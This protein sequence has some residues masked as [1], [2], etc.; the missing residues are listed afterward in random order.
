M[1]P[2]EFETTFRR[3]LVQAP[4]GEG[5]AG[6]VFRVADDDGMIYALKF[7]R[8]ESATSSKRKRFQN[9]IRFCQAQEH[10]NIIKVLDVGLSVSATAASPF[11]VMPFYPQTLRH[12][13]QAGI[14][15]DNILPLFA[16]ILDGV[17]AAHLV[18]VYHRDL[19]P[20]NV[21]YDPAARQMVVADFGV[22]HFAEEQLYTE[23]E[24]K[25]NERLANF[26]YSSPE[27]RARGAVVDQRA[28]IFALGLILNEMYTGTVIHGTGHRVIADAAP[29]YSYLDALVDAMIRQSTQERL[30][31]IRTIK[32]QLIARRQEFVSC[33]RLDQLRNVAVLDSQPD[34]PLFQRQVSIADVDYQG[35]DLVFTFEPTP[36]ATWTS[37]F[38]NL[39]AFQGFLG[40]GPSAMRFIGGQGMISAREHEVQQMVG[41]VR[42]W[43]QSANVEHDRRI[44]EDARRRDHEERRRIE[45]ELSAEEQ[46]QRILRNARAALE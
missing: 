26:L 18:G 17:E 6:W 38:N 24:T 29:A 23:V 27:Q 41:F 12:L 25:P 11:Y 10:P 44:R 16:Q 36:T 7:L 37:A 30:P 20:E 22:A 40:R 31:N 39:G 14:H 9:E 19:K 32:R 3:Y 35:G 2:K 34:D 42:S 21:L 5:G 45:T 43:T 8:P 46:R 13:M 15:I 4:I 28:D 1:I 33:Q